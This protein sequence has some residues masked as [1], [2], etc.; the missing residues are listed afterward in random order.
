VIT[1]DATLGTTWTHCRDNENRC[2]A[3][4]PRYPISITFYQDAAWSDLHNLIEEFGAAE[5]KSAT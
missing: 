2:A 1:Y 4:D 3:E 5:Q